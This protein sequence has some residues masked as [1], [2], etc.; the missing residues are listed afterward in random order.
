MFHEGALAALGAFF[1][2]LL[3]PV[4]TNA[5]H[6]FRRNFGRSHRI[7]GFVYIVLLLLGYFDL[8]WPF[9]GKCRLLFDVALPIAGTYLALTA[10]WSFKPVRKKTTNAAR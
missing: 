4:I 8:C 6:L 10:A 5:D 2:E 3:V 9:M 7:L 1:L